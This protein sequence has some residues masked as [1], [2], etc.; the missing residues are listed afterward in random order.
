MTE[1]L[2]SLIA[3][4]LIGVTLALWSTYF[5]GVFWSKDDKSRNK[6]VFIRILE[7]RKFKIQR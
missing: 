2:V 4:A 1:F 6:Y 3:G 5:C 7:R